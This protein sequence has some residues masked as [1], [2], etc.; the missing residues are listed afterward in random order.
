MKRLLLL[1]C[2]F[3]GF[4]T[5]SALGAPGSPAAPLSFTGGPVPGEFEFNTGVLRGVLRAGGKSLGLSEVVYLPTGTRVDRSNGILSHY[6]VFTKGVRY[7]AG[8][9]DWPS[10]ARLREDGSVEVNWPAAEDRPF[11][12]QAIYRLSELNTVDLETVVKAQRSLAGFESFVASYFAE[13][14]TNAAVSVPAAAEG[15]SQS[16]FLPVTADRGAWQIF[17]RA[18]EDMDIIQDGRWRIEPNPISWQTG[19]TL[20]DVL[21]CRRSPGAGVRACLMSS[22]RDCFA[23][24]SP[25]QTESHYSLYFSLFGSNL[26]AGETRRASVRLVI[27]HGV[28]AEQLQRHYDRYLAESGRSTH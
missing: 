17:P 1:Q 20:K 8:A 24:A 3:A 7:G 12:L 19:P 11:E 26:E 9:W 15:A 28:S 10:Q 6:R 2:L 16:G 13:S 5:A 22:R 27:N 14:F 25:H 21:A 23:V 18:K 4:A